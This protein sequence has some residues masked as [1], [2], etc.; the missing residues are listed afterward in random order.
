MNII[1]IMI[2]IC[3]DKVSLLMFVVEVVNFRIDLIMIIFLQR[4]RFKKLSLF[5]L[6]DVVAKQKF[7]GILFE[8]FFKYRLY[9]G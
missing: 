8:K 9:L 4:I 6:Y 2:Y 3:I 1:F 7:M 5:E